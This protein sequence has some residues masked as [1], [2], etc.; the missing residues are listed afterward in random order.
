MFGQAPVEVEC[1]VNNRDQNHDVY[2][3]LPRSLLHPYVIPLYHLYGAFVHIHCMIHMES[4]DFLLCRR[5]HP[6][7]SRPHQRKIESHST[8]WLCPMLL[9]YSYIK[10][11]R[12]GSKQPLFALCLLGIGPRSTGPI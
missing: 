5:H 2:L 12:L 11:W 8:Y 3:S 1:K 9:M 6:S 10:S 7:S 4:S